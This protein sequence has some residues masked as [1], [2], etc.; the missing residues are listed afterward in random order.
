MRNSVTLFRTG[1]GRDWTGYELVYQPVK[2][3][4]FP[5]MAEHLRLGP[6]DPPFLKGLIRFSR[7]RMGCSGSTTKKIMKLR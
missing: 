7:I 5:K 4:L 3:R 6:A 2:H 1:G